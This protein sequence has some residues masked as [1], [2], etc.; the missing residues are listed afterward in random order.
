MEVNEVK[1]ITL[2]L[3]SDEYVKFLQ[4]S[5]V[6]H[7]VG[8]Q[9]GLLSCPKDEQMIVIPS[10]ALQSD[11]D[12][13]VTLY[14]VSESVELES[15][16][17]VS[18][19]VEIT[20]HQLHFEKPIEILM[21]HS[22][23]VEDDSSEI[24]VLY[25]SGKQSDNSFT[26]LCQLSSVNETG[27]ASFMT[28]TLWEDFVYIESSHVCRYNLK[29]KGK[30][31]VEVRASLYTPKMAYSQQLNVK[32]ILTSSSSNL[33]LKKLICID[34]VELQLRYSKVMQLNCKEKTALQVTAEIP[35][36]AIGWMSKTDSGRCQ[37][38]SYKDIR[39][40]IVR[41]LAPIATDF[42]FVRDETSNFDVS[43]FA[44]VFVLNGLQCSLLPISTS[45]SAAISS[46]SQ[47]G[48]VA[49]DKLFIQTEYVYVL[50]T[51]YIFGIGTSRTMTVTRIE[52]DDSLLLSTT[53]NLGSNYQYVGLDRPVTSSDI[54]FLAMHVDIAK[55]LLILAW[56][57]LRDYYKSLSNIRNKVLKDL[58]GESD[59]IKVVHIIE[60]W[61]QLKTKD[62]T[63]RALVDIC[64]HES[65][66]SVRE[67]IESKLMYS[68]GSDCTFRG[69]HIMTCSVLRTYITCSFQLFVF[70]ADLIAV[71]C[72]ASAVK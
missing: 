7:T 49:G 48:N 50:T 69:K 6:K 62:A 28:A 46:S 9:G 19:V 59:F 55:K 33:N 38:I 32:L 44:P 31:Y 36:N 66:G 29:C 13:E 22:L 25:N 20:P 67:E 8:P 30:E 17:F 70:I 61:K 37:T 47:K 11:T 15:L 53:Q 42:S 24:T 34:D 57:L 2:Y 63:A 71:N 40:M 56:W 60:H 45:D 21:R 10:G 12:I 3:E 43:N 27:L 1:S 5:S 14:Q 4:T 51:D 35:L 23:Y 52:Q 16:E 64:C 26:S 58:Q 41:G 54:E 39:N 68:S 18:N 65:I 72:A